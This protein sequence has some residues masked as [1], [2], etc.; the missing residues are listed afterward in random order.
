MTFTDKLGFLP[1]ARVYAHRLNSR[2]VK[3]R[4]SLFVTIYAGPHRRPDASPNGAGQKLRL[5]QRRS[6]REDDLDGLHFD[7]ECPTFRH[8]LRT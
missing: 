7:Y 5:T 8:C 4:L 2:L 1:F 6:L 3:N